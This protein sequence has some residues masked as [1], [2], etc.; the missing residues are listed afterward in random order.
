MPELPHPVVGSWL[1]VGMPRFTATGDGGHSLPE[2]QAH[3]VAFRP[4]LTAHLFLF[5][6]LHLI[7]IGLWQR[8]DLLHVNQPFLTVLVGAQANAADVDVPIPQP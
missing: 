2:F 4:F 5:P 6:K 3:V 8:D 1:D 7:F